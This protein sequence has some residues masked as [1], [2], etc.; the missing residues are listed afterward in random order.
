MQKAYDFFYK[1][2]APYRHPNCWFQID[3]KPLI[4]GISREAQ[5]KDYEQFFTF[6]EAQ[7]PN[8]EQKVNGW[9]WISFTRPQKIH[10]NQ[11][12]EKEIINVAVS[13]HPNWQAGM[14]G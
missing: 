10:Y 14:G 2:D 13:Q 5:G 12:G 11:R 9:P 3:G 8:E 1:P 7:W 6:R 4:I